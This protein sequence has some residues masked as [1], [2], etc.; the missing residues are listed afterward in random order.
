[1]GRVEGHKGDLCSGSLR[2][3]PGAAGSLAARTLAGEYRQLTS[4]GPGCTVIT[5][6]FQRRY[7]PDGLQRAAG[8]AEGD[9]M[10][11]SIS[12]GIRS[13]RV[14]PEQ[15]FLKNGSRRPAFSLWYSFTTGLL[16]SLRAH[17]IVPVTADRARA[18]QL[19]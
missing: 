6:T 17:G 3:L 19:A 12:T 1:M 18:G 15:F 2:V 16:R 5:P 4:R 9:Q 8:T 7:L 14:G 11:S 13:L 10:P